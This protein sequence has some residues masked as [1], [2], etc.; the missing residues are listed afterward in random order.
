MLFNFEGIRNG[1]HN[2][3]DIN[4]CYKSRS[5]DRR[6]RY[7][8]SL[9]GFKAWNLEATLSAATLNE[10]LIGVRDRGALLKSSFGQGKAAAIKFKTKQSPDP[11]EAR[12]STILS[13]EKIIGNVEDRIDLLY[14]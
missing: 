12:D 7:P 4:V 10:F 3:Q 8:S 13:L 6:G 5:T 1:L 2:G 11:R 9:G 14:H